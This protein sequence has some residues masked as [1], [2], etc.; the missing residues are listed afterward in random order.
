VNRRHTH[1]PRLQA[2]HHGAMPSDVVRDA[3]QALNDGRSSTVYGTYVWVR[4]LAASVFPRAIVSYLAKKKV[5]PPC[6]RQ[7][8]RISLTARLP[9][10][11]Q[12]APL[13]CNTSS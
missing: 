1:T 6:A 10:Y 7:P 11:N 3:M 8:I 4:A 13:D 5:P 2:P 9:W 12:M